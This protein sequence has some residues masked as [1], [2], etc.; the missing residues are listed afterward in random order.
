MIPLLSAL[1]V[2]ALVTRQDAPTA[3]AAP[4]ASNAPPKVEPLPDGQQQ[5]LQALVIAVDGKTE[6]KKSGADAAWKAAAIDDLLDPGCEIRTGLRSTLTLRVG[7]NATLVI[8]RSSRVELPVI[9]Q[10]GSV[11]RTRAAVHRGKCDFRVEAIGVTSDFQ[12]LTPSA[13][14]AVRGTGFSVSWGALDGLDIQGSDT[15]R[16]R[17]LEVSYFGN[18]PASPQT[19]FLSGGAETNSRRPDPVQAALFHTIFPP[20]S[21]GNQ[22]GDPGQDP[23]RRPPPLQHDFRRQQQIDH[24]GSD[25]GR[26][27]QTGVGTPGTPPQH[28]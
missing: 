11:L 19:V 9:V 22:V 14:L 3:P 12:V 6:W 10:D 26:D 5:I 23:G 28:G 20:L 1:V 18:G 7:K 17:A 24:G 2:L 16:I 25:L 4:P 27:T 13:T 15:N 8:E 21:P